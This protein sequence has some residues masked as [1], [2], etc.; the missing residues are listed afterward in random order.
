MVPAAD[1][2][3]SDNVPGTPSRMRKPQGV[4]HRGWFRGP[5]GFQLVMGLPS[6]SLDLDGVFFQGPIEM[7]DI[8]GGTPMT[9]ET[10]T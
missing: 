10:T 5:R 8:N 7:D 4:A 9:I 6:S 2:A 1:P 3:S